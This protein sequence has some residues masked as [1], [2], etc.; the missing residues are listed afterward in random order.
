MT[1]THE[2]EGTT[3]YL[4]SK[5]KSLS[6]GDPLKAR[7]LYDS[8]SHEFKPTFK[9]VIQT[10]H[11]PNFTE[12]DFGLLERIEV[13]EFPYKYVD[14]VNPNNKYEKQIDINLKDKLSNI[15]MDFFHYLTKYYKLYK[16][17]G[18]QKSQDIINSIN[19]YKT[20]IDS[21]KTFMEQAVIKTNNET[22]RSTTVGRLIN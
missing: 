2:P 13:I 18:L 19:E 14:T 4:T 15:T 16:S 12:C 22:D 21:V 3:K 7:N 5:F 9:P 10:N 8:K 6:G 17:E 1:M 20:D 11:L